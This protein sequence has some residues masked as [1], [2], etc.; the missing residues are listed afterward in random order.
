MAITFEQW[1]K[2]IPVEQAALKIQAQTN[3]FDPVEGKYRGYLV[4]TEK[5]AMSLAQQ[6][7]AIPW[8]PIL[9]GVGALALVWIIAS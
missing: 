9:I 6:G 8:T 5:D 7:S 2:G 4:A 3:P 1:Q